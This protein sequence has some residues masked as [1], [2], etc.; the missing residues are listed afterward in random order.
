MKKTSIQRNALLGFAAV[1]GLLASAH[2]GD[3][4]NWSVTLGSSPV[5]MVP[6]PVVVPQPVY[7]PAAMVVQGPSYAVM[8]ADGRERRHGR[9]WHKKHAH[10]HGDF[11]EYR[12]V[13]VTPAVV[14]QASPHVWVR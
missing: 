14:V 12:A 5:V 9:G 11:W 3:R 8:R 1:L 2:A 13:E 7:V 4:L 10:G 6:A